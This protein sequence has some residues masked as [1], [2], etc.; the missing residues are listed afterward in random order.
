MEKG[1]GY[2][3]L[4]KYLRE[5]YGIIKLLNIVSESISTIKMEMS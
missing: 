4:I 5:K 2:K 3:K 1:F